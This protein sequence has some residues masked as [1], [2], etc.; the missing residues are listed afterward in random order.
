M[1]DISVIVP[2]YNV[3]KYISKC[4]DSLL[5]QKTNLIY[6]ILC[7]NDGSTDNSYE[8]L[9]RYSEKFEQVILINQE[10]RGLSF[11]RNIGIKNSRGKYIMFV[12]SD[13]YLFDDNVFELMY[14]ECE[15]NDLDFAFANFN[16]EFNDNNK[17]FE[18][19]RHKNFKNK[20]MKGKEIFKIGFKTKSIMSVVWNKLYRKSF[21]IENNL[22]F[23]E[24]IYYEDME[25]TPKVFFLANKVK[26]IDKLIYVYVQREGSIMNKTYK[27]VRVS[28]YLEILYSLYNFN[29]NYN[30]IGIKHAYNYILKKIFDELL[31]IENINELSFYY[32]DLKKNEL[33]KTLIRDSSLKYRVYLYFLSIYFNIK[34][35]LK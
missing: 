35:K 19:K 20:V 31:D 18:I 24:G 2:V 8:I 15:E 11:S 4:L 34:I 27:E 32:D 25:F 28:D 12:D 29:V 17:N 5:F 22:F 14:R 6:E 23:I 30:D 3:E 10:N 16:Y 13:D 1:I 21:I 26:H 9:K 33:L 7:I